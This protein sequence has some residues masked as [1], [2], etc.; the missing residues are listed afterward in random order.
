MSEYNGPIPITTTDGKWKV[1]VGRSEA[2][3]Q[4]DVELSLYR[5]DEEGHIAERLVFDLL[6]SAAREVGR[7]LGESADVLDAEHPSHP[8]R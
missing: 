2:G 1:G 6:P 7:W 8:N 3:E 4:N 5:T